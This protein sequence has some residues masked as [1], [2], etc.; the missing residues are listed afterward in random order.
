[1]KSSF[2]HLTRRFL[3]A[4]SRAEPSNLDVEWVRSHLLEGELGL[5]RTMP[6]HDRRH[7]IEVARRYQSASDVEATRDEIA[8]ALL[9][10]VGKVASG[11]GVFGR[12][13]ATI[14]GAKGSRFAEYHDHERIGADMCRRAGSS[15]LTCG[16]IDGSA[17][18]GY[19]DRLRRADDI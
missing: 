9:H 2:S 17:G 18:V 3:G 1:M 13:V 8:A 5:W 6:A 10:D 19:I 4:L 15:R 16:M 14:V 12:V 11:L 7:S